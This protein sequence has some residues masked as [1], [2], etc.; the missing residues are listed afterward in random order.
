VIA[1]PVGERPPLPLGITCVYI[2]QVH[3]MNPAGIGGRLKPM[4]SS[5]VVRARPN[6]LIVLEVTFLNDPR[7]GVRWSI[8]AKAPGRGAS[9]VPKGRKGES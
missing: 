8:V 5:S 1:E 9:A 7:A 2:L 3:F 4:G 6:D